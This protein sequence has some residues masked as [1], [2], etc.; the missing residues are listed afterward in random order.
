MS[1]EELLAVLLALLGAGDATT[2]SE[3]EDPERSKGPIGG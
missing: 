3:E 2:T 1:P